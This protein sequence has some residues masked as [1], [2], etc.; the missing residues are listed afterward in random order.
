MAA[1]GRDRCAPITLKR[2]A[3]GCLRPRICK[4][5]W[6]SLSK[7]LIEEEKMSSPPSV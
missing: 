2:R 6:R 4:R 3:G 5:Y 7:A 1:I